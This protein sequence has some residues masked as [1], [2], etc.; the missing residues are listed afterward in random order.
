[1]HN[2]KFIQENEPLY[3]KNSYTYLN[4]YIDHCIE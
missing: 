1:M 2:T 3:S 4:I